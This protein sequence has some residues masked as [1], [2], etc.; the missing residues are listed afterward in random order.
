[1]IPKSGYRFSAKIMLHQQMKRDQDLN[2]D[3]LGLGEKV[4]AP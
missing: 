3:R 4:R 1:M 2:K